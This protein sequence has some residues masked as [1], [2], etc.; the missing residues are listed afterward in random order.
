MSDVRASRRPTVSSRAARTVTEQAQPTAPEKS[1]V[2][3]P[4]ET[5]VPTPMKTKCLTSRQEN[6]ISSARDYLSRTA[7]SRHGPIQRLSSTYGA[8]FTHAQAGYRTKA[9]L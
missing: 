2:P 4:R 9:G 8:G 6:A 7:F 1:T 3:Q 5:K